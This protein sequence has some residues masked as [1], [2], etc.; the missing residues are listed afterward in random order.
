MSERKCETCG[1]DISHRW[2]TAR[3]CSQV[4]TTSKTRP[5]ADE[6]TRGRPRKSS[7]RMVRPKK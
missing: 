2:H 7:P 4:C 5:P 3:Y 6:K 1:A